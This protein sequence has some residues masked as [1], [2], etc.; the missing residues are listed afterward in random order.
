MRIVADANVLIRANTRSRGPAR[1]LLRLCERQPQHIL[2]LSHHILRKVRETLSRPGLQA[3]WG[4]TH[5]EIIEYC[6]ALAA[7][8]E[9]VIPAE[10]PRIVPADPEDDIILYT[11]I[12]G[13]AEVVC[14]WDR[15]FH[16]PEV[17]EFCRRRGIRILRDEELIRELRS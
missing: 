6:E 9:L 8:G 2:V 13:N 16:D 11:A 3:R 17:V 14:T 10:G 15:H 5:T 1:E 7:V 4:L 12:A